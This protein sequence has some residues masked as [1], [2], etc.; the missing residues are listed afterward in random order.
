MKLTL[1]V[2]LLLLTLPTLQQIRTT[3]PSQPPEAKPL[4]ASGQSEEKLD[5]LNGAPSAVKDNPDSKVDTRSFPQRE[6]EVSGDE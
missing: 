4:G 6:S 5:L 3:A 2:L 1:V